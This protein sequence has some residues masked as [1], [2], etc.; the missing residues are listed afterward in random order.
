MYNLIKYNHISN[1]GVEVSNHTIHR[2]VWIPE[3]ATEKEI[4]K[5]LAKI[6]FIESAD[7]RRFRAEKDTYSI[8]VYQVKGNIEIG[9]LVKVP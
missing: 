3:N 5:F 4:L 6:G 2:N 9:R 1:D 7:M 8:S